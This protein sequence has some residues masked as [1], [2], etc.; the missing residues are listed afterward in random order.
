[1]AAQQKRNT[2]WELYQ[3]LLREKGQVFGGD[4]T[5]GHLYAYDCGINLYSIRQLAIDL[6]HGSSFAIDHVDTYFLNQN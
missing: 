4:S 1:M 6:N 2:Q 3:H 5:S